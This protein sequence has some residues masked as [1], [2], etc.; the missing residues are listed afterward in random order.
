MVAG[1]IV[2]RVVEPSWQVFGLAALATANLLVGVKRNSNYFSVVGLVPL[3]LAVGLACVSIPGWN[4]FPLTLAAVLLFAHYGFSRISTGNERAENVEIA[5][6][7]SPTTSI[8]LLTALILLKAPADYVSLGLGIEGAVF[9]TAGFL[10]K[11]SFFRYSGLSILA[12]LAFKLLFV[13]LANHNTLERIFSSPHPIC[14]PGS[15]RGRAR[16]EKVETVAPTWMITRVRVRLTTT[17]LQP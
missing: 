8:A 16:M 2:T 5:H 11:E 15:P 10:L 4:A 9:V 3:I 12:M 1:V 6:W 7:V 13:D 14:M 17:Q